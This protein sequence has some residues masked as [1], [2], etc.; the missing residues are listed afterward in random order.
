[1]QESPV[2]E[3]AEGVEHPRQK[4]A[5]YKSPWLQAAGLVASV[6]VIVA[7]LLTSGGEAVIADRFEL[8][9]ELDGNDL[10][11]SVDTDLPDEATLA[12][13]VNRHYYRVGNDD[14][15]ARDYLSVFEPVSRWRQPRHIPLDAASWKADLAAHQKEMSG[16]PGL[17][18]VLDRIEDTVRM[19]ALLPI[20]QDDPRFGERNS[21]LS[22][23]ATFREGD[24]IHVE[25]EDS[26]AFPLEGASE[27]IAAQ[28]AQQ[29]EQ[30]RVVGQRNYAE[31]VVG[32]HIG[33]DFAVAFLANYLQSGDLVL[34]EEM[35]DSY[36]QTI[37]EQPDGN[38]IAEID[39]DVA[40]S[41][42]NLQEGMNE[43]ER[44]LMG[45]RHPDDLV[46]ALQAFTRGLESAI[47]AR[48]AAEFWLHRNAR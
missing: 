9:W 14:A 4:R 21:N 45:S 46:P 13:S 40:R 27:F 48:D 17:A 2:D 32:W 33:V 31:W 29:A 10:L 18:S 22:G 5:W 42:T 26:F 7:L 6:S 20:N 19:R 37:N 35:M 15:Y 36:R 41:R 38:P 24:R 8:Q 34:V 25:A 43:L 39:R 3:G 28:T 47:K 12:I 23:R 44:W 1:M 30:L 16:I 11:L